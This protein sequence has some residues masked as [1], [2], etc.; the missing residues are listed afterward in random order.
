MNE[1]TMHHPTMTA[2][3]RGNKIWR[4]ND[5]WHREDG[6]AFEHADG[7]KAWCLHGM[8]HR[9]DGPAFEYANGDKSWYLLGSQ[10]EDVFAWARAL[11]ELKGNNNP[12][13]DEINDKVQQ[14]TSASILD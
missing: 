11:L 7:S 10:Y 4:L 6:P 14:V 5:K 12:S 2:D 9:E 13:E 8:L 3:E 1:N